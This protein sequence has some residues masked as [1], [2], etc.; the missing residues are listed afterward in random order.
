MPKVIPGAICLG[1]G[2]F[3]GKYIT[4]KAREP[5]FAICPLDY[6]LYSLSTSLFR[7]LVVGLLVFAFL[8]SGQRALQPFPLLAVLGLLD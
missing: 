6:H 5:C 7:R 4:S 8:D 1:L 2:H 3:G